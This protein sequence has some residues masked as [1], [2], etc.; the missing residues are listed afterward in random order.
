MSL[1]TGH[2]Q[3]GQNYVYVHHGLNIAEFHGLFHTDMNSERCGVRNQGRIHR[4]ISS[5]EVVM[6]LG[7]WPLRRG[8]SGCPSILHLFEPPVLLSPAFHCLL[9]SPPNTHIHNTFNMPRQFFVGGNFK[10]YVAEL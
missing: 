10:M 4:D 6:S 8:S 9:P 3:I 2:N 7:A 1:K 5:L